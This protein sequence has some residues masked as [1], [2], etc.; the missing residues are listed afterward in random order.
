MKFLVCVKQVLLLGDAIA[1]SN[2]E[3]EVDSRFLHVEVNEG[4]LFAIEEAL[5]LREAL[6]GEVTVVT[7][8]PEEADAVLR[9]ALAMG[10]D[11]AVR[12]EGV[13]ADPYTVGEGLA[14]LAKGLQPDLILCGVQSSD[15]AHAAT[16]AVIAG[17][18]DLPCVAVVTS[19]QVD[20]SKGHLVVSR[21][22]GGGMSD[23]LHVS[24]PAVVAVQ[25]GTNQP[26]H[27]NLRAIKLA[28]RASIE[29]VGCAETDVAYRIRRLILPAGTMQAKSLGNDI[30]EAAESLARV[31]REY[32][33]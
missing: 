15:S 18:L 2:D 16:G 8:G 5:R 30:H 19:L 13:P 24:L 22:L 29:V 31:I 6:G 28:E 7:Y 20:A 25:T 33:T 23:R 12:V 9:R 11:R 27:P 32:V 3:R 26:R 21:E 10:V 14:Q 17:I 1:F 4:D